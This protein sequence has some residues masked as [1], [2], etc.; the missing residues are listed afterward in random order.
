MDSCLDPWGDKRW[1][2]KLEPAYFFFTDQSAS[3]HF[4]GGF[5]GRGEIGYRFWKPLIVFVDGGYF[6]QHGHS[7]GGGGDTHIQVA[8]LT[9]GL[10]AIYYFHDLIAGYVGAGPRLF[11][12]AIH[13]ESAYVRG[14]DEAFGLGGGFDAG[15]WIFPFYRYCNWSKDIF[16]D[17]FADYSLKTIKFEDDDAAS[18]NFKV[19]ISGVTV[20]L[21]LGIRF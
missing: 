1:Y 8:S 10:K 9:L 14:K 6:Q 12:V 7:I 15:L 17:L 11:M 19:N 5:T 2:F 20:G 4:D 13:N 3:N 21:G 18:D 16:L